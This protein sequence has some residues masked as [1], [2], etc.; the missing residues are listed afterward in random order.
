MQREEEVQSDKQDSGMDGW[1]DGWM[2][3]SV[4]VGS[5]KRSWIVRSMVW[6]DMVWDG[7][8]RNAWDGMSGIVEC[9]CAAAGRCQIMI[10]IIIDSP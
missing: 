9:V 7:M 2:L 10:I 5:E 3:W 8:V 6:Y 4:L 1:M